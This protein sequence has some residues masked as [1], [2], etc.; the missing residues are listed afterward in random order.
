MQR[1]S[2]FAL[3]IAAIKTGTM[4]DAAAVVNIGRKRE[5]RKVLPIHVVLQI[6]HT[7]KAGSRDLL[8][9]PRSVGFL[10]TEQVAQTSLN[11]PSIEIA[12]RADAHDRPCRLRRRAFANAFGRWIFVGATSLTPTAVV[13][14]TAL[15][16]IASPQ[17]PV[18][19][20]VLANRTQ[21]SQDLPGAVD[22]IDTP[23]PIPRAI[24]VL[25]VDQI[26]H[27]VAN[28]PLLWD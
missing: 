5:Q 17:Y 7:G 2:G 22:I 24:F 19:R 14:L 13:V 3:T 6:E 25:R 8:L 9:I 16:P 18:L 11:T 23:A 21:A 1:A 4:P 28:R 27:R 20:H 26:L 15:K 10:R 12:T